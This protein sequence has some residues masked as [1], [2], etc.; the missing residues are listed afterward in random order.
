MGLPKDSDKVKTIF[1]LQEKKDL[2]HIITHGLQRPFAMFAS[3]RKSGSL[4]RFEPE[5]TKPSTDIIQVLA[6][7]MALIY[8][9]EDTKPRC[10]LPAAGCQR[11]S[12]PFWPAADA[13]HLPSS[14]LLDRHDGDRR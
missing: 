4:G 5:L 1:E 11:V 7:Y 9:G 2:R 10:R 6:V 13:C 12:S 3:E 8:G 14:H